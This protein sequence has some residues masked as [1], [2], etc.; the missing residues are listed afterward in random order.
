MVLPCLIYYLLALAA[1]SLQQGAP[2]RPLLVCDSGGL[3]SIL[4]FSVE[5]LD[6]MSVVSMATTIQDGRQEVAASW[7]A[8]ATGGRC[9]SDWS[10]S[11]A[12]RQLT[13]AVGLEAALFWSHSD[14]RTK[15]PLS[16]PDGTFQRSADL[17]FLLLVLHV[18][19]FV[20]LFSSSSARLC[21]GSTAA[22]RLL[23]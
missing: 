19:C 21:L 20:D 7:L 10:V 14:S 11:V 15:T 23:L 3:R 12:T 17:N 18:L 22:A 6:C 16:F 13:G 1:A 2:V 4:N 9:V 8:E 5:V